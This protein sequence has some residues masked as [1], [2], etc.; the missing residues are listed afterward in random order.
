MGDNQHGASHSKFTRVV[1]NSIDAEAFY[2][3]KRGS[4]PPWSPPVCIRHC[5]IVHIAAYYEV[6][7]TYPT[8]CS[9]V[10]IRV[11]LSAE[12]VTDI[13]QFTTIG[14]I[15]LPQEAHAMSS[16]QTGRR[17]LLFGFP[18]G[19]GQ[20]VPSTGRITDQAEGIQIGFAMEDR[21]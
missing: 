17:T 3:W 15:F 14:W 1:A 9:E 7:I 6:M 5:Y 20:S 21:Q 11:W 18:R 13:L 19:G 2:F 12:R 8:C 16:L 10:D 4:K